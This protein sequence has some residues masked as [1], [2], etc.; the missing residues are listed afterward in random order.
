M[1]ICNHFT[2]FSCR[3][4]YSFQIPDY[5][6]HKRVG[7]GA[8]LYKE[9]PTQASSLEIKTQILGITLNYRHPM[10]NL[11]TSFWTNRI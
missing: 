1:Q 6:H 5:L 3:G 8:F 2:S 4:R 10:L 7:Q 9:N 11:R